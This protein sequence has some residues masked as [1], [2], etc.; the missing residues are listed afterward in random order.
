L[1]QRA[2]LN[3][4]ASVDKLDMHELD[5]LGAP[6][7]EAIAIA[8]LS[9]AGRVRA[10]NQ[11]A[12]ALIENTSRE[13]LLLVADGMGGHRGGETAAKICTKTI[14]RV[15]RE[16]HGT[17]EQRL[18]RGL[19]LANEEIYSHALANTEL[20]GMGTT[21]VVALLAPDGQAWVAWVGDSRL[22][23]YRDGKLEQLTQ[24]HSLMAEWITI[25]VITA[26]A[27][28]THPRRHE[29]T[30][31]LGQTPDVVVDLQPIDLRP[32]D[33]LLLCSDGLHGCVTD[34]VLARAL[35]TG[36][37][38]V[39]ACALV[40]AANANGGPDN[41]SVIVA[42]LPDAT[43]PASVLAPEP[44]PETAPASE[45]AA[46][47]PHEL[48]LEPEPNDEPDREPEPG[49]DLG[50][51]PAFA[52]APE[53]AREPEP[54]PEAE[55]ET[56]PE[57]AFVSA[58][59]P[60]LDP[61]PEPELAFVSAPPIEPEPDPEPA[62]AP[63][64]DLDREAAECAP[65]IAAELGELVS[66]GASETFA[67]P[68]LPAVVASDSEAETSFADLGA[69]LVADA[70]T[71]EPRSESEA[72]PFA[73]PVLE[74]EP[75]PTP[76][77]PIQIPRM[78]P[79]R[80]RRGLDATSLVVGVTT[81]L[82]VV[83][84][85]L[86]IWSYTESRKTP[87]SRAA[88]PPTVV[89]AAKPKPS[90]EPAPAPARVSVERPVEKPSV[91][92]VAK[93]EVAPAPKPVVMALPQ[94]APTRPAPPPPAPPIPAAAS[95]TP[96]PSPRVPPTQPSVPA[97]ADPSLE[98]PASIAKFELTPEVERFLSA[99]LGALAT[100]DRARLAALGFPNEP[101]ALAGAPGSRD[102]F[103]LVAADVDEQ[104]SQPGRVYLRL[105]V[106][107]AFRDASG[108]FR[109]QDEQRFI[110]DDVGGRLRFAGRWQE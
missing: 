20:R 70:P 107:Y 66:L 72:E 40:D 50:F 108:R 90:P 1:A 22:Y 3:R 12:I 69:E 86:A 54:V 14:E 93:P 89:H 33:R 68:E 74:R 2:Y 109:T 80:A 106:S 48:A 103:R 77:A 58:P 55:L 46:L 16:P 57:L 15:F 10:E 47:L 110:L 41:V 53:P 5:A 19:E 32:G 28:K 88:A 27:A 37:P 96:A 9:D 91:T 17:P 62:F 26:D 71:S 101:I 59:A 35:K 36:V 83:G 11:D 23:R 13:R 98:Q 43:E 7:S 8:S 79:V 51:E 64:P 100:D 76:S 39:A 102:G 25:G 31:A 67:M 6:G 60:A 78:T 87:E 81:T 61:E 73:L 42:V 94:P 65:E 105:I 104:R 84:L 44:M 4:R 21:A 85:G 95:A 56:E 75:F 30:R 92:P 97:A 45:P 29:L 82:V 49:P 38:D 24:D 63:V 34:T 99:W 52:V 18:V